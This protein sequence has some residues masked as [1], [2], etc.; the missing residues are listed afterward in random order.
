MTHAFSPEAQRLIDAARRQGG[1]NAAQLAKL[2][3]SVLAVSAGTAAA[4][5]AAAAVGVSAMKLIGA[6]ALAV[7]VGV[8]LT[9]GVAKVVIHQKRGPSEPLVVASAVR[10]AQPAPPGPLSPEPMAG[11]VDQPV[12][13]STQSP[14]APKGARKPSSSTDSSLLQRGA[15]VGVEQPSVLP[16]RAHAADLEV[17]DSAPSASR[18][19]TVDSSAAEVVALEAALTALSLGNPL[20]ALGTVRATRQAYPDGALQPEL[21]V[22]EVEALC[23]LERVDEAKALVASMSAKDRTPLAMERLR[24]T[25]AW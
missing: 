19:L 6:A 22:L 11:R 10:I 15:P 3:A 8:S 16:Q 2:S 13:I 17:D 7:G 24:R 12:A 9:L 25:C 23:A 1:P 5:G 14:T 20:E 21:K 18:A 4:S